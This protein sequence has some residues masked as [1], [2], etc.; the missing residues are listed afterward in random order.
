MFTT[1]RNYRYDVAISVSE[2]DRKVADIIV[3]ELKKLKVRYYYYEDDVAATWGEHIIHPTID[4]YG[5]RS[6]FVLLMTSAAYVQKYWSG[7]ERL[8]ASADARPGKAHI[9]QLKL[10]ATIVEGLKHVA[11][12]KWENNPSLIANFLKQKVDSRKSVECLSKA[13][14]IALLLSIVVIAAVLYGYFGP[15]PRAFRKTI[16]AMDMKRI[17]ISY[18]VTKNESQQNSL[19]SVNDTFFIS[20]IEVTVA[21][22]RD[23]CLRQKRTFPPQPPLSFENGPVRNVTWYEA[24]AYCQWKNGRL[25]TDEEWEYAA[26]AGLATHYSGSDN[27]GTVAV[28]NRQKPNPGGSKSP[29]HFGIYDMSGNIAEWSSSWYDSVADLKSVKGGAYNSHIS[30]VNQ[31]AI[32]YRTGERPDSRQPFIGF[33]V[34]WDK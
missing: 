27:A 21:Q 4:I 20:N 16:P 17:P 1:K 2:E 12:I 31:L 7:I 30:P 15:K 25:P 14:S 29:N 32:A 5:G 13:K 22:F 8:I 19:H 9:L 10:D 3:V 33:R 28:Y 34:A 26:R 18:P 24:L 23:F 6:R 11:H